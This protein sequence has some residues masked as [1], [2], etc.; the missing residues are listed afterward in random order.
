MIKLYV[1]KIKAGEMSIYDVPQMWRNDVA[2]ALENE[3]E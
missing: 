2:K 1:R 3:K